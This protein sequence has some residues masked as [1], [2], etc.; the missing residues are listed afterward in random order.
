[1]EQETFSGIRDMLHELGA[2]D[3]SGLNY[4]KLSGKRT[5]VDVVLLRWVGC[6]VGAL[7]W[8]CWLGRG[9]SGGRAAW[10]GVGWTWVAAAWLSIV[11]R[12]EA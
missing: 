12:I 8:G 5:A 7:G 2:I 1:M 11:M 4:R 10:R 9:L 3:A 6:G